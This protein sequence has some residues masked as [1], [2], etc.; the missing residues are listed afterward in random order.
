MSD[1]LGWFTINAA[2]GDTLLFSKNDYTDQKIAI[3]S[4][5]DIPVYLEPVIKL[6]EVRILGQT[7]K[8]EL[9]DIMKDYNHKGFY[10]DGKPPIGSLLMNPLNDLS[11]L[12]GKTAKE[13]RRFKAFSKDE[14]E[15]ADIH[16]RYTKALVMRATN[17]SDSTAKKFM[18]Y[19]TPTSEDLKVWNDYELIK[20]IKKSY[21]Y[22]D[23]NKSRIFF[24]NL[25]GPPLIKPEK[26]KE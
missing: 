24:Q 15:Y 5:G 13:V 2:V 1:E 11:L 18:E 21:E 17:A 3:K 4:P 26:K 25:N 23:S 12:F 22:Y 6:A 7:K 10:Y 16:R 8:Q 9:Q 14:I 19:Y 20:Q